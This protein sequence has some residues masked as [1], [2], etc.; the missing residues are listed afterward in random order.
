MKYFKY[1]PAFGALLLTSVAAVDAPE[2]ASDIA[3][4]DRVYDLRGRYL[5]RGA[6][7]LKDLPAGVYIHNGVKIIIR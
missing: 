1:M 6:E 4:D 3:G 5:G 2:S 7:I